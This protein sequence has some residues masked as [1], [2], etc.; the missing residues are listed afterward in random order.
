LRDRLHGNRA[1]P[2]ALEQFLGRTDNAL[3]PRAFLIP[4]LLEAIIP[5]RII[6]NSFNLLNLL[7]NR[8]WKGWLRNLTLAGNQGLLQKRVSAQPHLKVK[9]GTGEREIL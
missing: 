5:E 8:P 7:S 2:H 1:E 6:R 3:G 4:I 9:C